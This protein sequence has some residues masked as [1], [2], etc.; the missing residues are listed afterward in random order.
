MKS[1]FCFFGFH[2]WLESPVEM[3]PP[4]KVIVCTSCHKIEYA[5]MRNE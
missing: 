4:P 5:R 2:K 3:Y 1:V